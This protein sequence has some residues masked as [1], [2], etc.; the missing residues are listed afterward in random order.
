M[1]EAGLI[2]DQWQAYAQWGVSCALY[3]MTESVFEQFQQYHGTS[4]T[5]KKV[6]SRFTMTALTE[7]RLAAMEFGW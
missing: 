2:S 7:A 4:K 3:Q 5:Q 1:A 6:E